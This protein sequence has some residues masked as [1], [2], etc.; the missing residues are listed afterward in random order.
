VCFLRVQR[1]ELPG[2]LKIKKSLTDFR[3]LK[4]FRGG[5]MWSDGAIEKQSGKN[6]AR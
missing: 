5:W 6:A 2:V 3:L 1:K 4:A